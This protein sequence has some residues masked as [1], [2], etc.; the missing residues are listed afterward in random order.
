MHARLQTRPIAREARD[1]REG[2]VARNPSI[3]P[4]GPI[5]IDRYGAQT[6]TPRVTD[7]TTRTASAKS[8][9][10]MRTSPAKTLL[11]PEADTHAPLGVATKSEKRSDKPRPDRCHARIRDENRCHARRRDETREP[12]G[13][14]TRLEIRTEARTPKS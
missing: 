3:D 7:R 6:T 5:L 13:V 14:A 10:D 11:G 8:D 12:L 4:L 1:S 2:T 9:A